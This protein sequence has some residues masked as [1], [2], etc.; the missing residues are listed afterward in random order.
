MMFE[1]WALAIEAINWIELKGFSEKLALSRAS[2]KLEIDDSRIMGLAHK[3]VFE[4]TRRQNFIDFLLNSVLSPRSLKNMKPGVKSFLRLYTSETRFLRGNQKKASNIAKI[5]RSIL[6][7]RQLSE[8]EDVLGELLIVD[9][10]QLLGGLRAERKTALQTFHPLWLVRYFF[11]IFGRDQA[12]K[13]LESDRNHPPTYI[14]LNTLKSSEERLLR[15]I[16]KEGISLERVKSLQYAYRIV[17]SKLPLVR[18]KSF[19]DG[20]FY[21]QDKAS[22]LASEVA[23]PKAGMRVLDVCAAPGAKSTHL[24]QMMNN[25][26]TIY[27]LDYSKRRMRIWEKEIERMG[28]KIAF[29]IIADACRSLP[30]K[31]LVDLLI[32]DP[33]CTSTGVFRKLPSAKWR[34]TKKSIQRMTSIQWRMLEVCS[35]LITESG[36]LIYSTCSVLVEENEMLIERFLKCHSDFKLVEVRPRIGL[37]G[38]RGLTKGQRLY[39]HIHDCNGFFIVKMSR[40]A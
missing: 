12:L 28:V 32:L 23:D 24:A 40:E 27:S 34:I 20:L 7:W 22:S 37:P 14:R 1:A 2:R 16:D 15:K 31:S 35:S 21:I 25:N 17:E 19:K 4:T 9:E 29:P 3:L 6:G 30:L 36:Y 39:P 8:V 11:R 18:T 33:P 5:G 10:S 26:G 38:L 13:L